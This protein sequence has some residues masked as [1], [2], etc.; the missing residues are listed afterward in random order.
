MQVLTFIHIWTAPTCK[1]KAAMDMGM[2]EQPPP[3]PMEQDNS[4]EPAEHKPLAPTIK[5][6]QE[7]VFKIVLPKTE[8]VKLVKIP[9]DTLHLLYS[10]TTAIC[11]S[12]QV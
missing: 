2:T 6:L 1:E 12:T 8:V 9:I 5:A 10:L 4:T 7:V 3:P 11:S